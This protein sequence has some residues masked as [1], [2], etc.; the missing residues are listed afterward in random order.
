MAQPNLSEEHGASHRAAEMP[1]PGADAYPTGPLDDFQFADPDVAPTPRADSPLLLAHGAAVGR[2]AEEAALERRR[3]RAAGAGRPTRQAERPRQAEHGGSNA[4]APA[5][6]SAA[7]TQERELMAALASAAVRAASP[8][9]AARL[10][11]AAAPSAIRL[12]PQVERAL[13]PVLPALIAVVADAARRLHTDEETRPLIAGLPLA[14]E[15]TTA[16]LTYRLARGQQVSAAQAARL[17]SRQVG[18]L[19][20]PHDDPLPTHPD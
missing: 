19:G 4:P 2:P 16:Q 15:R 1:G 6:C 10:M 3:A 13:W 7:L 8:S 18:L 9:A 11:A 12:A 17:L 5:L 20:T 14:L